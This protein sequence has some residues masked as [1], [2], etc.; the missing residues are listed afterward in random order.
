[1]ATESVDH[2]AILVAVRRLHGMGAADSH[3]LRSY[4]YVRT[5]HFVRQTTFVS[6]GCFGGMC[7]ENSCNA[8]LLLFMVLWVPISAILCMMA[9]LMLWHAVMFLGLRFFLFDS[10]YLVVCAAFSYNNFFLEIN[11]L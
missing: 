6:G 7:G 3:S 10:I 2:M 8:F 4:S 11:S 1:M 9:M 5:Q